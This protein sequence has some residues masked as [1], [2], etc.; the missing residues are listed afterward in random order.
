MTT[1]AYD[2]ATP[3]QLKHPYVRELLAIHDM[4]RHEMVRIL[5]YAE[6]LIDQQQPP[7]PEESAA[8][9]KAL[10]SSGTQ[11]SYM[12]HMH[13]DIETRSMFPAL[14]RQGL[15]TEVIE[16]LNAEH[17]Q[18]AELIDAFSEAIQKLSTIEPQVLHGDLR[19]LADALQ[20]H[21][22][23]EEAHVCPLLA[24]FSR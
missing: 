5:G 16:R 22:A 15:K 21:L 12:L 2:G 1:Q 19:R 14:Q 13:H 6:E 7:A 17:D 23:Y 11:Y 3:E 8:Y 9:I 18:I 20:A 24:H 10:I 4:F